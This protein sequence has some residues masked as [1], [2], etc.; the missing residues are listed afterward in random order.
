M[1]IFSTISRETMFRDDLSGDWER[2]VLLEGAELGEV[3]FPEDLKKMGYR[4]WWDYW[5]RSDAP[6][7]HES[8]MLEVA[9]RL[10]DDT[11]LPG[12]SLMFTEPHPLLWGHNVAA[13]RIILERGE[14]SEQPKDIYNLYDHWKWGLK[15][16]KVDKQTYREALR[17]LNDWRECP[18]RRPGF[19]EAKWEAEVKSLKKH[20]SKNFTESVLT[21]IPEIVKN[22][23]WH[24]E[25]EEEGVTWTPLSMMAYMIAR[26]KDGTTTQLAGELKK[27]NLSLS[28]WK[29][30]EEHEFTPGL[31]GKDIILLWCNLYAKNAGYID[32]LNDWEQVV[33]DN[34]S[35][36]LQVWKEVVV[37]KKHSTLLS[38]LERARYKEAVCDPLLKGKADFSAEEVSLLV[39]LNGEVW[40]W[41]VERMQSIQ[42]MDLKSE[43]LISF[44]W[45]EISLCTYLYAKSE[46][47]LNNSV[48]D[49]QYKQWE[50]AE[51]DVTCYLHSRDIDAMMSRFSR[52]RPAWVDLM[53]HYKASQMG[54]DI[55]VK[56]E[57]VS[58]WREKRE[59]AELLKRAEFLCPALL[60]RF[61]K[62]ALK[63]ELKKSLK[64]SSGSVASSSPFVP[65][66]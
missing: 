30:L 21:V 28:D 65:R 61:E 36:M 16:G 7:G 52:T 45:S 49:E 60:E 66:F 20:I 32:D 53:N 35:R 27:F 37:E 34:R 50:R 33:C 13:L 6:D 17:V 42:E 14:H 48:D 11:L 43:E 8:K 9:T 3:A 1:E 58:F 10:G 51:M 12:M 24:R 40:C 19:T 31:Q 38:F 4:H 47:G 59:S 39:R 54:L 5:C 22:R 29:R 55:G 2:L 26:E 23:W 64:P 63:L 62:E 41:D 57:W 18:S 46:Q 15:S 56:E 44:L 25:F